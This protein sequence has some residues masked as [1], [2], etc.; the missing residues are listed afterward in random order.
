MFA[1]GLLFYVAE[2]SSFRVFYYFSSQKGHVT[3]VKIG[4]EK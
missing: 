1:F 3:N 2:N 4:P